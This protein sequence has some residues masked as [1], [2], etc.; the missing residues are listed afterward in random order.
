MNPNSTSKSFATTTI[1]GR[2]IPVQT[3][4]LNYLVKCFKEREE[5]IIKLFKIVLLFKSSAIQKNKIRLHNLFVR[6]NK[7]EDIQVKNEA[8]ITIKYNQSKMS[9][10]P[11]A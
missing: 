5:N 2:S 7:I 3:E 8:V 11:K 10:V 1:V 4:D 9:H 6:F